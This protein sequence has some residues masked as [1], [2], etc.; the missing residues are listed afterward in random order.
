MNN[1]SYI[2]SSHA[3]LFIVFTGL[4]RQEHWS[5]FPFPSPVDHVLSELSTM[6]H[7]SWVALNGMAHSFIE[8][9]KAVIHVISFISFLKK[10]F[11]FLLSALWWLRIRGLCRFQQYVNQ[12]LPEVQAGYRKGRGTRDQIANIHWI[13][14]KAREFQKKSTSASLTTLKPVWITRNCR[15]FLTD[16]NIRWSYLPPEKSV[17]RSRSIN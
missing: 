1:I 7:P 13:I 5:G 15:K 3:T 14:E 4:S 12:E 17:C 10:W 16:G 6:T 9:D 11:W 8:L 2:H